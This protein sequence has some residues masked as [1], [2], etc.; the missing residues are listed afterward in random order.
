L[1]V[2]ADI[3]GRIDAGRYRRKHETPVKPSDAWLVRHLEEGKVGDITQHDTKGGPHLPHH[4]KST[5]DGGRGTLSGING[6][7][8]RLGTDA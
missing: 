1:D 7:C 2:S 3:C 8:G 5:S 4:D 6:N